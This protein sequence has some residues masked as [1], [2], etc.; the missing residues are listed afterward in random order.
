VRWWGRCLDHG[1]S[2]REAGGDELL[3]A[4]GEVADDNKVDPYR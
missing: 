1:R 3:E 4:D 2:T